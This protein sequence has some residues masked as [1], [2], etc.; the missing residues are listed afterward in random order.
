MGKA[1]CNARFETSARKSHELCGRRMA[2]KWKEVIGGHG[3]SNS[4]HRRALLMSAED[5]NMRLGKPSAS[6]G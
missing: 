6:F 4:P 3:I 1:C 5:T 2:F